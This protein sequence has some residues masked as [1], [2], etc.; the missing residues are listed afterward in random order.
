[1][2]ASAA[3]LTIARVHTVA[4]PGSTRHVEVEV[5]LASGLPAFNLVGLPD[6]AVGREPERVRAALTAHGPGAAAAA[7]HRQPRAR[8]PA[9]RKAGTST[10]RSRSALL[11]AMGV[12][13]RDEVGG[14]SRSAS[15][16]STARSRR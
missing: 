9:P 3:T 6:K 2:A 15:W 8:R 16:H 11:A 7:D 10:C 12:L 13:P 5:Q 1:M 4:F 14:R